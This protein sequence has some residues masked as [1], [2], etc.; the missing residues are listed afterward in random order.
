M[1]ETVT[2]TAERRQETGT[3]A[4][5]KIRQADKIPAV[6]YGR[7]REPEALM[8]PRIEA[9]KVVKESG[10]GSTLIELSVDGKPI[11]TLIR[12]IQRHPTRKNVTHL[13]F[14]E[15]HAGEKI[16][17]AVP[18]LLVGSPDGVRNAGGVL[19]QFLREIEV[20]VLPRN[21]PERIEL[22]VTEL[23]VGRS[24]HVSDLSI[25]NAEVLVEADT[26]VCTVVPPRVEEEPVVEVAEEEGVAEPELIRKAKDEEGEA[27]EESEG[28]T[29]E[30]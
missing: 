21:I 6:I 17:L 11:R 4:A 28:E 30:E 16:K 5:R 2:L 10:G 20:E 12:E 24:L 27:E 14:L 29:P 25:E 19:E 26:T 15:V 23:R 13:D 3:G 1:A 18:L 9:E 7:G 8:V 22:D